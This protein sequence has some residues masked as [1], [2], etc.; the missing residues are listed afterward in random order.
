MGHTTNKKPDRRQVERRWSENRDDIRLFVSRFTHS[1]SFPPKYTKITLDRKNKNMYTTHTLMLVL[2][3]ERNSKDIQLRWSNGFGSNKLRGFQLIL[4][5][6]FGG[7]IWVTFNFS[8][9]SNNIFFHS[10][11]VLCWRAIFESQ[12]RHCKQNLIYV[13][14]ASASGLGTKY[15]QR[16]VTFSIIF[17]ISSNNINKKPRPASTQ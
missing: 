1:K 2:G 9:Q 11:S 10:A 8:E 17:R 5:Y 14:S 6:R 15:E 3:W 12:L 4:L 7:K 13:L 16:S